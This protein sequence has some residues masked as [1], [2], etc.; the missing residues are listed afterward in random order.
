LD[1]NNVLWRVGY[2]I[3]NLLARIQAFREERAELAR[4][5]QV[6][7]VLTEALKQGQ[8]PNFNEW[9]HTCLDALVVELRKASNWQ[10]SQIGSSISADRKNLRNP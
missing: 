10:Q 9:T 2:S 1:Q 3:N 6:A 4:T 5:K 8:L 7:A